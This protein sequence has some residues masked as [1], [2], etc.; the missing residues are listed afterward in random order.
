[1][2]RL[3]KLFISLILSAG[4]IYLFYSMRGAL[5]FAEGKE[6]TFYVGSSSSEAEIITVYSS[7]EEAA[8]NLKD[9]RGES[10]LYPY[11]EG[12]IAQLEKAY[13]AEEVFYESCCGVQSFYYYSP[14]FSGYVIIEGYAVNL[15]IASDGENIK[16][17]TPIIFGGY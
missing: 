4:T 2:H 16:I 7:A 3:L 10:T 11:S 14:L 12:L 15:H 17:G 13:F 9:I 5:K 6:Y 8:A 1:M